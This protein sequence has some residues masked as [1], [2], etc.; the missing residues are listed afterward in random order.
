[1]GSV[2]LALALSIPFRSGSF[3][4]LRVFYAAEDAKVPM[5]VQVSGSLLMLL[6]S[7]AGAMLLP[8]W[9]MA[10]WVAVASSVSYVYQFV[11]T[12]VLTVRRFG[13]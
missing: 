2:L 3:Y 10:L 4:L 6:L 1:V 8:L 9:S 5:V 11:L 13:D 7:W 12:H